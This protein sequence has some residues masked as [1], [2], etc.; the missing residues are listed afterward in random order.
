MYILSIPFNYQEIKQTLYGI[1]SIKDLKIVE[2]CTSF[3]IVIVSDATTKVIGL[4]IA[5]LCRLEWLVYFK[6]L[7]P[8]IRKVNIDTCVFKRK[9]FSYREYT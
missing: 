8:T 3:V 4:S 9:N 2:L 1:I 7:I 5:K 6:H